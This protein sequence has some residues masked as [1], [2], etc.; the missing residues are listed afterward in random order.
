MLDPKL[1]ALFGREFGDGVLSDFSLSAALCV[2]AQS[3]RIA[4]FVFLP[5]FPSPLGH[6]A[7]AGFDFSAAVAGQASHRLMIAILT[8]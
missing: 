6:D 2:S 5:P 4:A 7:P 3:F 8:F 1:G